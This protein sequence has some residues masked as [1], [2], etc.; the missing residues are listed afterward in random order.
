[1]SEKRSDNRNRI[2]REGENTSVRTGGIGSVILMK[3]EK[4]KMYTVG[5]WTRMIQ[6]Q[7]GRNKSLPCAKKKNRLIIQIC[8]I[9]YHITNG[10]NYT[11]IELVEKF[12]S[13]NR[14]SSQYDCRI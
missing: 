14:S 4:K 2:L 8:L 3:T 9:T 1:M 5:V 11:V 7:E 10:G 13:E 12:F 6:S